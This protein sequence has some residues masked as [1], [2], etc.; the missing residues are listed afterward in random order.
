MS[1]LTNNINPLQPSGFKIT[2]D[3]DEYPNLEFFAQSIQHPSV[4]GEGQEF[5]FRGGPVK[6]LPD[7]LSFSDLSVT[8]LI[9]EDL[10]SY[11]EVLNWMLRNVDSNEVNATD[12]GI[13]SRCDITVSI[14]TSHNNVNKQIKYVDAFPSSL[15][16]LTFEPTSGDQTYITCSATFKY[17]Y[18]E[19]L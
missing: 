16:D 15:S 12:T 2:I 11:T 1:D 9:D 3:S 7:K 4:N 6:T 14:L 13:N 10:N 19:I 8:I 5:N 17:S 18:F